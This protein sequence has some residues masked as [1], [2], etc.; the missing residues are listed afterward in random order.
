MSPEQA[1]ASRSVDGR[2]DIYS[3]GCVL[4]EMLTGAPPFTGP[5]AQALLARHA[6]DP[7]APIRTVRGTVPEAMERVVLRALAKVP[8]D[9]YAT[10]G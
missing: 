8:A 7:V 6:V 5:S 4:Y 3:L 10:A 2:T 9:R 1:S